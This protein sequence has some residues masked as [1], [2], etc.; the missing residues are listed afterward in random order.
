MRAANDTDDAA[1]GAARTG[2]AAEA[3]DFGDD[4]IAVHGV[5]N[6]IARDEDVAVNVGKSDFRDDEAVTVLMVDEAAAYF[7][8]GDSFVLREFLGSGSGGR[9]CSISFFT[10]KEVT[11]VRKFLDQAAF[12]EASEHLLKDLTLALFD[13][14]GT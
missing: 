8:A 11:A 14:E 10:T 2:H 1:L 6:L 13:L 4:G 7:V 9:S 5:F 12:L 3:G